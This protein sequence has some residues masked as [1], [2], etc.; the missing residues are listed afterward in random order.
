LSRAINGNF[1]DGEI[2]SNAIT[3]TVTAQ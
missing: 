1:S 3:V 2:K